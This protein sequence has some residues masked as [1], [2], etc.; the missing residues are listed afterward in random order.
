MYPLFGSRICLIV[1]IL[2]LLC[3]A[4]SRS[5]Y[6]PPDKQAYRLHFQGSIL[7][8][9]GKYRQASAN[10]ARATQLF[11][12]N[13]SFALA[14]G[15]CLGRLEETGKAQ[16]ILQAASRLVP[17]KDPERAQKMALLTFFK[18][19]VLSY[20]Q[21]HADAIPIFRSAIAQQKPLEKPSLISVYYNA[22][23]YSILLNQSH[24]QNLRSYAIPHYHLHRRD[25]EKALDAFGQAV[26]FD[27]DNNLAL[28]N[29]RLLADTLNIPILIPE[30]DSSFLKNRKAAPTFINMHRNIIRDLNLN[31]NDELV[32][33]LDISGS[34]VMEKVVCYN[35][36]RFTAM[37]DLCMKILPEI[38]TSVSLG[39]GTIGGVCDSKPSLWFSSG[40]ISRPD[41]RMKLR[42]L[43]PDGTTPLLTMLIRCPELF[44]QDPK[45]SKNLFLISDGANTCREGGL[46]M[47]DW[48]TKLA[49]QGIAINVLTFLSTTSD[50]TDAFAEYLCLAENTRGNII[51]LDNYRCRLEPFAFDLVKTCQRKVP[52][53]EKSQCFPGEK[54]IWNVYK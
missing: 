25:M 21:A 53:L 40:G 19:M 41:L 2:F 52:D 51:Y 37:K 6:L 43:I 17:E 7:Y 8:G 13:F 46:D 14:Y 10:F 30:A 16:K 5:S 42:F 20:G 29:Y 35:A 18:G 39:I 28:H 24:N 12:E 36:D 54:N 32:F 9:E 11:P 23:G 49:E 4:A 44:S 26:K 33:L 1:V 48:A 38:D 22:L 3:S 50:N 27:P 45:S 34:M 31:E 47:C 15:L